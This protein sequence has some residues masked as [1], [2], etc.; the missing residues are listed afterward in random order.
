MHLGRLATVCCAFSVAVTCSRGSVTPPP[1]D[2]PGPGEDRSRVVDT[3]HVGPNPAGI[4]ATAAAVYIANNNQTGPSSVGILLPQGGAAYFGAYQQTADIAGPPSSYAGTFALTLSPDGKTVYALNS[5]ISAAVQTISLLDTATRQFKG[6]LGGFN[7]P[8][9]MAV[10]P[11]G[12]TAYVA[13][14]GFYDYKTVNVAKVDSTLYLVNLENGQVLKRITVQRGP[15]S[16]VLSADARTLYCANVYDNSVSVIDTNTNAVSTTITDT[17]ILGPFAMALTPDGKSLYVTNYGNPLYPARTDNHTVTVIDTATRSVTHVIAVGPKPSGIA[18]APNG[19][20][21]YVTSY[22][23][24]GTVSVI[25]V[26]AA[27]AIQTVEVGGLP[28]GVAIDP[29]GAYAYVTN[30]KDNTVSVIKIPR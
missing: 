27:K 18:I 29:A 28:S 30:F 7:A 17:S 22:E 19:R 5:G 3:I 13:N 12:K 6:S 1:N 15:D 25:D 14:Y 4:V 2:K 23:S 10:L 26:P 20:Y 16:L 9:A 21:A 11:D 8:D 24:H